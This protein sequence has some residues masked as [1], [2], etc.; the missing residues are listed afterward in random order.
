MSELTGK[1][2]PAMAFIEQQILGRANTSGSL[3]RHAESVEAHY[4]LERGLL[5][6]GL[7]W[8]TRVLSLMYMFIV[9][10]KEYWKME[11]NDPIFLEIERRWSLRGVSVLTPDEE[12]GNSVYGFVHR[13]RNAVSHAKISFH[14]KNLEI[15]DSWQERD[16]YRAIV[17]EAE[18]ERFLEV[19][20]EMMANQRNRTEH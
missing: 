4:D 8:Q 12:Y 14:G 3:R 18:I 6:S 11:Q 16:V 13:L 15:W 1:D 9:Y 10:P 17:A 5:G 7:F 19:V 2:I 20:G